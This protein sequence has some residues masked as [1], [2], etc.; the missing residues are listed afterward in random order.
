MLLFKI[1]ADK[2]ADVIINLLAIIIV[3][4]HLQEDP[5]DP[6]LATIV[7]ELS[8]LKPYISI[9]EMCHIFAV[10]ESHMTHTDSS[11]IETWLNYQKR[12]HEDKKV[13]PE[14]MQLVHD[15]HMKFH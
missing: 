1:I 7:S 5:L 4:K 6:M 9:K 15:F 2:N 10:A 8:E 3:N 13:S 14:L 11:I 12:A